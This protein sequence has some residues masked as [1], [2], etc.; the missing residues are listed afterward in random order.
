MVRVE[1]IKMINFVFPSFAF[2]ES[3]SRWGSVSDSGGNGCLEKVID[4]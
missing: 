3:F 2:I 1:N 4:L